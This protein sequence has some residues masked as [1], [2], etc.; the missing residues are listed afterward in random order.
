MPLPQHRT[1]DQEE[2]AILAAAIF[3][4]LG[5]PPAR[6]ATMNQD[7]QPVFVVAT[8]G[9]TAE[10]LRDL[11]H[12]VEIARVMQARVPMAGLN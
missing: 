9:L 4:L 6:F 7:G 2:A 12:A 3:I 5:E 1:T 8:D 10:D 11:H